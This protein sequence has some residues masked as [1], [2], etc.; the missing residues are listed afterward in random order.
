MGCSSCRDTCATRAFYLL[1]FTE[2][3]RITLLELMQCAGR[4][5]ALNYLLLVWA[6][7]HVPEFGGMLLLQVGLS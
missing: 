3:A 2:S 5:R 4:R 6:S 7:K 1:V